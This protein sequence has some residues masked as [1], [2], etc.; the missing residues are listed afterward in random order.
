MGSIYF[1]DMESSGKDRNMYVDIQLVTFSRSP[2]K[3]RK[4]TLAE[5]SFVPIIMIL[6]INMI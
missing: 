3:K 2:I 1:H 4:S 5:I 6:K